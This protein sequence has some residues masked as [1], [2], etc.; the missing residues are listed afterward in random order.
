M[1]EFTYMSEAELRQCVEA[2]PERVNDYDV[3]GLTPLYVAA[4]VLQTLPLTVWLLDEKG[5]DVN[6]TTVHGVTPLHHSPSLDILSALLDR[7]ANPTVRDWFGQTPLMT[8]ARSGTGKNVARLLEDPRVRATLNVHDTYVGESA[9]H[10]ACCKYDEE[11]A[12]S[13][14]HILLQAGG[15]PGL[16]NKAGKTPW[17]YLQ[18]QNPSYH[19]TI[20]L[21]EQIADA[22]KT[23]FLVKA[24]LAIAATVATANNTVVPSCIDARVAGGQ[25][26]PCI[27]LMPATAGQK[28]NEEEEEEEEA[29][30]FR[31]RLAFVLGLEGGP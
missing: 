12:V 30:N 14:I 7:G 19:T 29:R 26:L 8:Q 9:L 16:T 17:A 1:L 28:E 31:S 13:L 5:A 4:C 11:L 20:A 24:R 3:N 18:N 2:S 21:L 23:S 25:P 22:E 27:T 10:L 6:G 15:N